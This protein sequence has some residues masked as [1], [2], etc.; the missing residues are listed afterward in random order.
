M[1]GAPFLTRHATWVSVTSPRP[2]GRI[3][4]ALGIMAQC[5]FRMDR[6]DD[7]LEVEKRWRDLDMRYTRE[8]VGE[9]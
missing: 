5:L 9:T 4:N 2:S 3:A 6:W 8:R 7:V 1:C